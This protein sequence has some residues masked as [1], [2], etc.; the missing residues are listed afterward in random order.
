VPACRAPRARSRRTPGPSYNSAVVSHSEYHIAMPDAA[1]RGGIP[2]HPD[3]SSVAPAAERDAV[4]L[5]V[6]TYSTILRSSGDVKLRAF[7]PAHEG[8]GSSLHAGA[9]EPL[10][11]AGALIYAAHRLPRCMDRVQRVVL[12]QLP[13]QFAAVLGQSVRSWRTVEAAARRR[14][15]R[16]DGQDT[17]AV[18]IA[19]PSDVDDVVPTLVAY[20]IE[21]NKL[22]LLAKENSRARAAL[23]RPEPPDEAGLAALGAALQ[24]PAE[25]WVRLREA[26]GGEF[27]P[28]LRA[29]AAGEKDLCVNL[30]GGRHVSYAKLFDRWWDPVRATLAA[31]DL[32]GRPTYFVSSNLHSQVNLLSGYATRRADLLWPFLEQADDEEAAVLVDARGRAN[33][34]NILYYAARLWHRYHPE[35]PAKAERQQEEEARGIYH[36][37]PA[38]GADIGAQIVELRRLLPADLDPRLADLAPGLADSDAVILNVDYPLGMAAYYLL[39]EVFEQLDDVRGVYALGKAATLN[40]A[41]GDVLI[42][43]V[44]Y[45][46]HSQNLYTFPNAFSHEAVA[47]YLERGSVLDNQEAVTVK[48]TF[49]QNRDYLELFYREAYT[50]V[51]MEAGPYLSALYEATYPTRH[52]VGES[53]HFRHLPC[54][55][56]L[57]HYASDTPYTRARTLGGRGLSFEGIDSTYAAS[58][59]ILRRI[60]AQ[61]KTL[62]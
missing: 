12:G 44:V 34:E 16:Y 17:L 11:D 13:E 10:P 15:W 28:T 27:W 23:A 53:V 42:A 8:I 50:V 21:W 32:L 58:V 60:L 56:G 49:L 7:E 33:A 48:G 57:I 4:E 5:Y 1:A 36:V 45:D 25:D 20:Q 29:I 43:D 19:S 38:E 18:H 24:F 46:E 3:S 31:H 61:E 54:D 47:P 37:F 14:V 30:L 51:E 6:R 35:S 39:R 26:L 2:F 41:I 59:A 9:G 62:S 52:P 40:G 22:H 55:F